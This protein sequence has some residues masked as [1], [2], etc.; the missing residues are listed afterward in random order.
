MPHDADEPENPA[1]M[2]DPENQAAGTD[3]PE[4]GT[5]AKAGTDSANASCPVVGIGA[6]AGGLEAFSQLLKQLPTSTGMGF[7]LVQHLDPR[8]DS[9]L[10][11]LLASHTLM[12]V[13]TRELLNCAC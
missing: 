9:M 7:V 13:K 10:P 6:S 2:F 12:P 3:V 11:E 5:D 4:V 8:H 1:V